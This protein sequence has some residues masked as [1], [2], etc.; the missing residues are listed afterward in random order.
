MEHEAVAIGRKDEGNVE[1]VGV[2]QRLLHAVA[3]AVVVVL[4]LNKSKGDV[5]LVV[6]NVI[7][8]F[9]LAA[10]DELAPDDDPPLGEA[11]FLANLRHLIPAGLL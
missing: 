11:N 2:L 8:A 7:G 1:R 5:R 9:G 10:G 4:G 3:D 6:E